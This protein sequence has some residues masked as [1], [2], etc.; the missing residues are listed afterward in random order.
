MAFQITEILAL[1]P[2]NVLVKAL[3]QN[4]LL[5]VTVRSIKDNDIHVGELLQAEIGFDEILDWK[6]LED[7]EDV[8]SGIWQEQ[9]GIHVL[10][11]IHSILDYGDG[12]TTIDVYL[13]NGP[14]FFTV[15]LDAMEEAMPDANEGLEITV[16]NLFLFPVS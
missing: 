3:H 10:G 11:R 1:Q 15:N 6:A 2:D 16:K 4:N 7:F 14:E 5:A 9:D 12:R 13:Q 8:Q